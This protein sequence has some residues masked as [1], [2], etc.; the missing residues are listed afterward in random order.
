MQSNLAFFSTT[1]K[2]AAIEAKLK[3]MED[4]SHQRPSQSQGY[5]PRVQA[6]VVRRSW[7]Q[8]ASVV[9]QVYGSKDKRH[10]AG[11]KMYRPNKPYSRIEIR[12]RK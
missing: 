11:G 9:G 5:N 8:R 7:G 6:H 10:S 3:Q 2:I 1:A 12:T 4:D